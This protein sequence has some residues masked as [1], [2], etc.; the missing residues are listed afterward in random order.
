MRGLEVNEGGRW[1]GE[2]GG[3]VDRGWETS[4]GMERARRGGVEVPTLSSTRA[5]V[6]EEK[7]KTTR[8]ENSRE[9]GGGAPSP[10]AASC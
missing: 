1:D 3:G 9:T 5:A 8:R 4:L 6:E 10:F 2:G 7:E